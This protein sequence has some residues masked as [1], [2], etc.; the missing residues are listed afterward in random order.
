MAAVA[1]CGKDDSVRS[2]SSGGTDETA[3]LTINVVPS[4]G[5]VSKAQ[6]AGHGKQ[7][8]DNNIGTLDVFVFSADGKLDAYKRFDNITGSATGLRLTAKT[9]AKRIYV[10]A[11]PH[12]SSWSGA[13]TLTEFG[14]RS[15]NLKSEELKSFTMTGSADVTLSASTDVTINVTRL[16]SRIKLSGI[17][18]AFEGTPYAGKKLSNVKIFL[19]N[20]SGSKYYMTG[21]DPGTPV[22]LN[23]N[24]LVVADTSGFGIKAAI[25]ETLTG[26]IGESADRNPSYFYCYENLAASESASVK[27]TRL[28]IQGDLD[29]AT[30]YYPIPVN[31]ENYGYVAANGHKGVKRN[32]SYTYSVV[33][34][35]P[36][37]SSPSEDITSGTIGLTVNVEDWTSVA[38]TEVNF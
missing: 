24:A 7:T 33:I 8:D 15:A 12:V 17:R 5:A 2:G 31:R 30:Y 16:I 27:F 37:S 10:V 1:G 29:G 38:D 21:G 6:G 25:A 28:V 32:T 36:G 26:T 18:C 35:R 20:A 13:T 3:L 11:N 22:V 4:Q 9:G 19:T 14:K 23:K 34:N